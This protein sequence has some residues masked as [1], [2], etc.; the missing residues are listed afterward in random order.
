M[1]FTFQISLSDR[2]KEPVGTFIE[3]ETKDYTQV[4]KKIEQF[5]K[6]L[7]K[8]HKNTLTAWKA[9]P[10]HTVAVIVSTWGQCDWKLPKKFVAVM[11]EYN[12]GLEVFI[13]D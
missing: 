8:F 9:N 7:Q 10:A 11:A 12:L 13:D 4:D 5:F 3:R 6:D 1:D 2:A